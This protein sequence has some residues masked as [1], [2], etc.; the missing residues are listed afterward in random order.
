M[1]KSWI[2]VVLEYSEVKMKRRMSDKNHPNMLVGTTVY[3][4]NS[5]AMVPGQEKILNFNIKEFINKYRKK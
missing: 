3:R 2:R 1:F 5:Q 4:K